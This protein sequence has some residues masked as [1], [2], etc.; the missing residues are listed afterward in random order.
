M[1]DS[2]LLPTGSSPLEVAAAKAC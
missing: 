1:S 2:R